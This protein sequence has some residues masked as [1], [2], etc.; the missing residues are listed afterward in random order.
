MQYR[1]PALCALGLLLPAFGMAQTAAL[2][3]IVVTANRH[4]QPTGEPLASTTII[5]REDIEPTQPQS[6][7][8]LLRT[9]AG[10]DVSSS[11]GLGSFSSVFMRGTESDH[12]LVL[13]DGVRAAPAIAGN[14]AFQSMDPAQIE[15]IEIVR[16]P[17]STLY[18][19]D[20]IGGVI[21]IF[22][23]KLAGPS[24]SVEAGSFDTYRAQAGYGGGEAVRYSVNGAYVDSG[25]FSAT[26]P[27][28]AFSFDP[29]DDGY[30][31]G[32][33][34][35]NL[36]A[37]LS[38]RATLAVRG[39]HADGQ[40][41]FDRGVSDTQN[42]TADVSLDVETLPAWRQRFSVGYARDRDE[43]SGEFPQNATSRRITANWQNE[44]ALGDSR[45]LVAGVD[46]YTDSGES[47]GDFA[48]DESINDIGV[49]GNLRL[50]FGANDLQVG[51]RYDEHSEFGSHTT[52]Q[53]A[54]G[55][56][57]TD[58]VRGFV[59]FGTAFKAPTLNDLFFP[60]SGNPELDPERSR[61]GEAGLSYE[62]HDASFLAGLSG[63]YTEVDDLIETIFVGP[64]PFDFLN[65]NVAE[66]T[67]KGLEL[68]LDWRFATRWSGS[69]TFTLQEARNDTDGSELLRRPDRKAAFGLT[70]SF[71]N[72]GSFYTEVLLS[73]DR[74]DVGDVPLPG[75][76][77]V[78]LSLQYPLLDWLFAE[79]RVENLLD[80]DYELAS[81][82]N[83]SDRAGYVGL[84]YAPGSAD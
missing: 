38:Q 12:V 82:F 48:F 73:G 28:V 67:I 70:R 5:S 27:N 51:A 80:K 79:A 14:F 39:W 20:A 53:L 22:T 7:L 77:I 23:R 76:G 15:R 47:G 43:T 4:T 75:Y 44:I 72:G 84:R 17:R 60:G 10:I 50:G 62:N 16:G 19:S 34:T 6:V 74:M 31:Q 11:G 52:G 2:E 68:D 8:D 59:A 40:L 58:G 56:R 32:S 37:A 57:F 13:V 25:G 83:T 55:R 63:F 26:N 42:S 45:Q 29:D 1:V 3:P 18:G 81:G 36:E 9:Q 66:A 24:A 71:P 35:A 54:L 78:N 49:Y 21:Q 69:A 46:Y 33:V 65:R 41:E 30:E 61:T 64:G